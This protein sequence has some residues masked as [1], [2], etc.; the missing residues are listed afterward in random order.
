M[1]EKKIFESQEAKITSLKNKLEKAQD[2]IYLLENK[3]ADLTY[4][5]LED[6][7]NALSY[8]ESYG[9]NP[10]EVISRITD[11][12]YDQNL[13]KT[14]NPLVPYEGV[15]GLM[16]I[17]KIKFLNHKWIIAD[18]SDGELWGEMLLEYKIDD[19]NQL[20]L[21]TISSLIYPAN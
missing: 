4:F 9:L 3:I 21:N 16:K 18:F 20:Q 10:Q 1:N 8:L 12:I 19:K 7:E 17:N 15:V 14:D 2:S 13:Q 11:F 5:N 6:N